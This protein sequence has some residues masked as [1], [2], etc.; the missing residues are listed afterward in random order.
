VGAIAYNLGIMRRWLLAVFVL[1]LFWNMAG[2]AVVGHP[3]VAAPEGRNGVSVSAMDVFS[4]DGKG[5]VDRAHGLMDELPDLPDSLLRK[6]ST[7]AVTAAAPV[8]PRWV[9]SASPPPLP[10]TLLHRFHVA[11]PSSV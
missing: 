8:H 5:L 7:K 1:Q 3:H 6:V 9:R 11:P 10:E 4:T 2:F